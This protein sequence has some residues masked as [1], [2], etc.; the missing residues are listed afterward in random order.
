M[1]K[2]ELRKLKMT[3]YERGINDGFWRG[4]IYQSHRHLMR[5]LNKD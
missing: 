1:S 4:R 2:A 3:E 5:L